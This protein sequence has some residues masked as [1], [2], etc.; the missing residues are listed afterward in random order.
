MI[1][2]GVLGESAMATVARKGKVCVT[3]AGGFIGSW[4]VKLLLSRD[5][6]VHGTVREPGNHT[7]RSFHSLILLSRFELNP[8]APSVSK[9]VESPNIEFPIHNCLN[10]CVCAHFYELQFRIFCYIQRFYVLFSAVS[11]WSIC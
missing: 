4:V 2:E 1:S 5:Y 3:G 9:F 10:E 7:F 6:I 11:F 8:Y